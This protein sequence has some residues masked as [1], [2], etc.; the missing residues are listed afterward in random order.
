MTHVALDTVAPVGS[1]VRSINDLVDELDTSD[2]EKEYA[3]MTVTGRRP[4]HPKTILKVALYAIHNCRFSLRKMEYDTEFN[5]A[6]RWLTG[7]TVIDHSTLGKFLIKFKD[8][9][10]DLFTQVVV[11]AVENEL[12]DFDVL[13]IDSVKIRANASYK[14]DRTIAGIDKEETRIRRRIEELLQ[15]VKNEE[16]AKERRLLE[17]R[18]ARLDNAKQI[19]KERIWLKSANKTEKEHDKILKDEKINITDFDAHKMQQANGEINPAYSTTTATDSKAD[20]I[21]HYQVNESDNDCAALLPAI[22]GSIQRTE[23]QP[24]AT[25]DADSG[26]FSLGNVEELN[27]MGQFALIPDKR[28]DVDNNNNQKNPEFDRSRFTYL[29]ERDVYFCP[30]NQELKKIAEFD[31]NEEIYSRYAN[32][33]ACAE[34]SRLKDCSRGKSRTIS[35][36]AREYLKEEMRERLSSPE[37]KTVYAKRAHVSE[38]PFGNMKHNLKY[39]I[40]MR[41]E[42]AKA[43]MEMG[44]LCILHNIMKIAPVKYQFAP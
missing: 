26:F 27:E 33:S 30:Q 11:V 31:L 1:A 25:V 10:N 42:R 28:F 21:T 44:L 32:V 3:L 16:I 8:Y 12:V 41:R 6:Y 4:L 36:A 43:S 19:L 2:I 18:Q 5:L 34:C 15:D 37:N 22:E 39:K 40:F 29:Q 35:R 38:S 23:E 20:I 7:N 9:T 14:Q 13:G 24:H 17:A